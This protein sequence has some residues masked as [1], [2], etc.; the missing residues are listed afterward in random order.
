MEAQRASITGSGFHDFE[1]KSGFKPRLF[2]PNVHAAPNEFILKLMNP[3]DSLF[4]FIPYTPN[5][6]AIKIVEFIYKGNGETALGFVPV[7]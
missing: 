6:W 7:T 3:S 4:P 5:V 1:A 2:E